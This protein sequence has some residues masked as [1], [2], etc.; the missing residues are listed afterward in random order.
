MPQ[1]LKVR[2]PHFDYFNSFDVSL[3]SMKAPIAKN[4]MVMR[5]GLDFKTSVKNRIQPSTSN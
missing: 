3:V 2:A 4:I 1:S 5:I